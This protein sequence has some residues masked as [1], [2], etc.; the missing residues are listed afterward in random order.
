MVPPM[1]PTFALLRAVNV[2]GANKVPMAAL[3]A[4]VEQLGFAN[5]RTLLASGNLLFEAPALPDETLEKKLTAAVKKHL[6]VTTE[7]FVRTAREVQALVSA[8]PFPAEAKKDPAHLVVVFL[9]DAPAPKQVAA[10]QAA[11]KGRELI[12]ATKRHL[13]AVYSDGIGR[14]K[15]TISLIERHLATTGTARNWNTI[16]KLA[17]LAT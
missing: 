4:T 17:A 8:N 12:K 3:R 11:I 7:F 1:S 15:L 16:L 13:Y 9:K 6:G 10:L 2:A 14:S 5:V